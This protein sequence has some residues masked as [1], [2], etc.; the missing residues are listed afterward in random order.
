VTKLG[1]VSE[2]PQR[3]HHNTP[4]WVRDGALFSCAFARPGRINQSAD[5]KRFWLEAFAGGRTIT[6]PVVVVRMFLLM[7]DHVHALL[8]IST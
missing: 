6:P 7:P 5:F 4:A 1:L 3:L 8:V 2:F